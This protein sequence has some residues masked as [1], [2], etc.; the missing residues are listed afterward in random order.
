MGSVPEGRGRDIPL[1]V[2]TEEL[3][4]ADYD[5]QPLA[6]V[7]DHMVTGF[8]N[9]VTDWNPKFEAAEMTVFH[10][11]LRVAGTLDAIGI[12]NGLW[13]APGW[14]RLHPGT[15]PRVPALHRPQDGRYPGET[16]REH[17]PATG[18]ANW[19]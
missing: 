17:F 2:L 3:T 16:V 1:P 19:P 13:Q 10:P 11:G 9:W 12:F 18:T 4:G 5:G 15:R 14:R 7:T 8:L 6:D